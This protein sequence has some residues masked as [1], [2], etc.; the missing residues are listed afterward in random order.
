[1]SLDDLFEELDELE[2]KQPLKVDKPIVE[3]PIIEKKKKERKPPQVILP[4]I[5]LES[6]RIPDFNDF[7]KFCEKHRE[8]DYEIEQF[9]KHTIPRRLHKDKYEHDRGGGGWSG[10]VKATINIMLKMR[11]RG[12]L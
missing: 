9:Y 6:L 12:V 11:K 7:L 10:A 8:D 3:E 5:V 1:M 4:P 2:E